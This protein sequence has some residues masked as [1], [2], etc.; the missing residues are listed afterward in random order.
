MNT[1]VK[2]VLFVAVV[3]SFASGPMSAQAAPA[4]KD[5]NTAGVFKGD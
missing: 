4:A 1:I 5:C 2:A 3:A